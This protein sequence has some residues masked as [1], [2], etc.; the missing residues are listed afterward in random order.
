MNCEEFVFEASYIDDPAD[1]GGGALKHLGVC[2]ECRIRFRQLRETGEMLPAMGLRLHQAIELAVRQESAAMRPAPAGRMW[3]QIACACA[4]L[5]ASI[6]GIAY[7]S[8][9]TDSVAIYAHR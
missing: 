9:S 4:V 2:P 5:I 7:Q 3:L 1:L 6:A 8:H